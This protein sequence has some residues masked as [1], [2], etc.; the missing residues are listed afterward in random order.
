[1]DERINNSHS[2]YLATNIVQSNKFRIY[3]KEYLIFDYM[4]IYMSCLRIIVVIKSKLCNNY[5][6]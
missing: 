3:S 4:T 2:L 5:F 1:M 6:E